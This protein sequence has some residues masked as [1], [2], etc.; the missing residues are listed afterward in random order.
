MRLAYPLRPSPAGRGLSFGQSAILQ[1][2]NRVGHFQDPKGFAWIIENLFHYETLPAFLPPC[3]SDAG[4]REGM[5]DLRGFAC[6]H[7]TTSQRYFGPLSVGEISPIS[8][9]FF[10]HLERTLC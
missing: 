7:A 3:S 8:A 9:A 4:L 1:T 2:S 5:D 10:F 6:M